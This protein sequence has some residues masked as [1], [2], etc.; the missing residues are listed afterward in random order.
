MIRQQFEINE[1]IVLT[2]FHKEFEEYAKERIIEERIKIN[3]HEITFRESWFEPDELFE[4]QYDTVDYNFLEIEN[5]K[6]PYS[7]LCCDCEEYVNIK[8]SEISKEFLKDIET[9]KKLCDFVV[10]YSGYH[11]LRNPY[12]IDNTLIFKKTKVSVEKQNQNGI[13]QITIKKPNNYEL[14]VNV[15]FKNGSNIVKIISF[16][17]LENVIEFPDKEG[18]DLFDIEFYYENKPVFIEQNVSWIESIN[19]SMNLITNQQEI[20]LRHVKK[21][22]KIQEHSSDVIIA[23]EKLH[24]DILQEYSYQSQ[25]L[26]SKLNSK[27][28][29]E[30]LTENEYDRALDI[31]KEI[32]SNLTIEELWIF[33]P[34]FVDIQNGFDKN[35]D[36]MAILSTNLKLK[37]FI[38]YEQGKGKIEQY[39]ESIKDLIP[40]FSRSKATLTL[41]GTVKHFHDRFIFLKNSK[42]IIGY[43]LGT[44]LNSFGENYSTINELTAA[45]SQYV[46]EVLNRDLLRDELVLTEDISK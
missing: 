32:T 44:S 3:N 27:Y 1:Q 20:E 11:L 29:F 33:D 43:Q 22:I 12:S 41:I 21:K 9:Y 18:W 34:Y 26:K 17:T 8:K 10:E 14:L 19:I 4:I 45:D 2:L 24:D 46:F 35:Y 37:K 13:V 28:K 23:G 7:K 6:N 30:L 39:K 36:I 38:I 5:D 25:V 31:F 16:T 40:V 42:R 15:K